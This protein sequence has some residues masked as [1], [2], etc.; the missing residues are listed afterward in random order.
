PIVPVPR[1]RNLPL[2]FAQQRLWFLNE[3]EPDN[4]LYNVPIAIGMTGTLNTSALE[5]SLN[6]IVRRHEILRTTFHAENNQPV[7]VIAPQSKLS[8]EIIDLTDLP[9]SER[10]DAVKGLAVDGAKAVFN[11]EIGPLFR[12]SVLRLGSNEHILLLNM[13]HI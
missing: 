4:P 11:L 8:L 2:S 6:E 10:Q 12:A 7:Q 9:A 3:L 13:H 5:Q 1:S